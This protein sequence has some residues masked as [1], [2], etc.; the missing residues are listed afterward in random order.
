MVDSIDHMTLKL[1][2]KGMATLM[3][4]MFYMTDFN[5]PHILIPVSFKLVEKLSSCRRLNICIWT[6]ME[7]AI[8]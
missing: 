1:L 5:K 6:V 8:L 7:G 2:K 4:T 3:I